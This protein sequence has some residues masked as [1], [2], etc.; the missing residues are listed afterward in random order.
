MKTIKTILPLFVFLLI[1][2]SCS[3]ANNIPGLP[4][5]KLL[6]SYE[7]PTGEYMIN[8]YRC[9]G[10]ATVDSS[11]RGEL[12]TRENDVRRNIYW[13]YH[14]SSA[15]VNWIDDATVDINGHILNIHND[16]YDFRWE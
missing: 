9:D 14:E 15:S 3:S 13:N 10:G 11:I 7:S 2:T 4:T 12:V 16:V 8:I 1:L 6:E 5:G